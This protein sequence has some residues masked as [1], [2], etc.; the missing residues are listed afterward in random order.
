MEISSQELDNIMSQYSNP[1]QNKEIKITYTEFCKVNKQAH[2]E[3]LKDVL[4]CAYKRQ[5]VSD[6]MEGKLPFT[7]TDLTQLEL[8]TKQ[9]DSFTTKPPYMMVTINPRKDVTFAILAKAVNKFISKKSTGTYFYAYEVRK[10]DEGLHCHIIVQYN[11][12]P[13][14]FKRSAKST[15]SKVCDSNN[16]NILNFKFIT[17]EN[18]P[19][20]IE[21][22]LGDKK[23]KKL[24]GV[25]YTKAYRSTHNIP[26]YFES[27]PPF[28]CRATQTITEV[29]EVIDAT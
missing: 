19:S 20:K 13:Y 28:P 25:K 22:L 4:K 10:E 16:P 5:M 9:M 24:P 27:S 29:L 3:A 1:P 26:E 14:D 18:L 7:P 11:A 2:L 6:L 15:F 21:Y 23:D 12:K 8:L 17:E